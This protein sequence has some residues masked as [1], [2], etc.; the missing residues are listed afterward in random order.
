M[1]AQ[2]HNRTTAPAAAAAGQ[3]AVGQPVARPPVYHGLHADPVD[4]IGEYD[5]ILE[6]LTAASRVDD[7]RKRLSEQSQPIY[8]TKEQLWARLLA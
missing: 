2:Q 8:G 6:G 3:I 4:I 7:T 5:V 1:T